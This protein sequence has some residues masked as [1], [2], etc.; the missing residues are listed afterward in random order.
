MTSIQEFIVSTNVTSV[1]TT[2]VWRILPSLFMIYGKKPKKFN[3]L[4]FKRWK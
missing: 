2:L 3:S 1:S 4:D